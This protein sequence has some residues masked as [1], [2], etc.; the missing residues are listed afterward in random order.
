MKTKRWFLLRSFLRLAVGLALVAGLAWFVDLGEVF[1]RFRRV[2]PWV[3]LIAWLTWF[4]SITAHVLRWR[5][6]LQTLGV[7]IGFARLLRLVVA[8]YFLSLFLPSA[9]GG[10]IIRVYGTKDETEGVLKSTGIIAVERYFG[11]LGT[12]VLALPALVVTDFGSY[13]PKLAA[14]VVGLFVIL[15]AAFFIAADSRVSSI[16]QRMAGAIGWERVGEMID[17][18]SGSLRE[19]VSRPRLLAT[20]VFYSVLMKVSVAVQIWV[21]AKGL[22]IRIDLGELLVFL[23][24][25]NL[26][27]TLPFSIS[28]LGTREVALAA[29]FTEMGLSVDQ[30]TT[31]ALLGL[32]WIYVSYLAAGL[33]FLLPARRKVESP[34]KAHF[35]E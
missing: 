25:Y 14:A 34:S 24:L 5:L 32:A 13:H 18:L 29:F 15:V 35:S 21:L 23:P 10:D 30:A 31:L 11:F 20:M 22:D 33:V 3:F 8:G 19:F 26:A 27:C 9:I 28:G 4:G 17:R 2:P 1:A 16:C 6:A 7:R 12:F